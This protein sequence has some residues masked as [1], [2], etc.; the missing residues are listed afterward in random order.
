MYNSIV[1]YI[2]L[3][4]LP[5]CDHC[6]QICPSDIHLGTVVSEHVVIVENCQ[7]MHDMQTEDG[8]I[9]YF[10]MLDTG[11]GMKAMITEASLVPDT[12]I[13][14]EIKTFAS[15][16]LK[17]IEEDGGVYEIINRF[18]QS[19]QSGMGVRPEVLCRHCEAVCRNV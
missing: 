11:V 8:T 1:L 3:A 2:L 5:K 12:D 16:V 15:L 14:P 10:Y 7:C 4:V 13:K 18:K 17:E 6:N 9:Y 19:L